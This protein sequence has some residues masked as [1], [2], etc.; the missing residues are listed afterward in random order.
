MGDKNLIYPLDFHELIECYIRTDEKIKVSDKITGDKV[1]K[2][3]IHSLEM[4]QSMQS[5]LL[6]TIFVS[7]TL[8]PVFY[9]A[10]QLYWPSIHLFVIFTNI[11]AH[12]QDRE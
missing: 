11:Y 4:M 1:A 2:M 5:I 10:R 6:S 8:F 3:R 7:N 9:G 12:D